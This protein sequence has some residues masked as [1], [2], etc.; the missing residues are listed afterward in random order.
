MHASR[1]QDLIDKQRKTI[2]AS[3]QKMQVIASKS[4]SKMG[5]IASRQKK[6]CRLGMEKNIHGHRF[7]AQHEA[8]AGR[9]SMRAG[10]MNDSAMGYKTGESRSLMEHADKET[11]MVF[12]APSPLSTF[13]PLISLRQISAG[14]DTPTTTSTTTT[15]TTTTSTTSPATASTAT[16][17]KAASTASTSQTQSSKQTKSTIT[18]SIAAPSSAASS[19]NSADKGT[20]RYSHISNIVK[21]ITIDIEKNSK[22]AILGRNGCGKRFVF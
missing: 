21:N 12:P 6:L 17:Q 1:A 14:Y 9:S 2:E 4:D 13:G 18:R 22:I 16:G 5:A 10:S 11:R 3:I 19:S 20:G 15:S 8:T 7:R